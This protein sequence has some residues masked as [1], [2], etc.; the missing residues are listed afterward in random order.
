MLLPTLTA[1]I[2]GR[3]VLALTVLNSELLASRY[4]AID[5][6][7][8][9]AT[10]FQLLR[11][12]NLPGIQN[13]IWALTASSTKKCLFASEKD[14]NR[15]YQV[16]LTPAMKATISLMPGQPTGMSVDS[17]DR[18]VVAF[19]NRTVQVYVINTA[20]EIRLSNDGKL[21]NLTMG[22]SLYLAP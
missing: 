22:Y 7:V 8:Y 3:S 2:P 17:L 14:S 20:Q 15:I 13:D 6:T 12:I 21:S 10:T 11:Q 18:H 16:N 1:T 4:D 9:D 19:K 5:I